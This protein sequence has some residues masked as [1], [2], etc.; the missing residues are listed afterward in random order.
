VSI[1]TVGW[2]A[3]LGVLG[4]AG[5]F[6]LLASLALIPGDPSMLAEA[7]IVAALVFADV[8][9]NTRCTCV[10]LLCATVKVVVDGK[11]TRQC[12]LIRNGVIA[13][14][15]APFPGLK[16]AW[17]AAA[18]YNVVQQS[19]MMWDTAASATGIL[20]T[21]TSF[22]R[23]AQGGCSYAVARP[24][25]R[26][27][28]AR[29]GTWRKSDGK[30]SFAYV[31]EREEGLDFY[32]DKKGTKRIGHWLTDMTTK[33]VNW[34]AVPGGDL[35][36]CLGRDIESFKTSADHA[37]PVE[38]R[39]CTHMNNKWSKKKHRHSHVPFD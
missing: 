30:D 34:K 25:P 14:G 20:K 15:E 18:V 5:Q 35:I 1:R 4:A 33:A 3:F 39:M 31:R 13:E 6:E 27:D 21:N 22:H 23:E 37:P 11:D 12:V 8:M 10:P 36:H 38:E 7:P 24:G 26:G 29:N 2:Y 9:M 16:C 17:Q 32:K 19:K 28:C